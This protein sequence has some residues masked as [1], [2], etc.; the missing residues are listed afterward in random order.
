MGIHT[1]GQ[2]VDIRLGPL[3]P[4]GGEKVAQ[5]R[6]HRRRLFPIPKNQEDRMAIEP[7]RRHP[8]VVDNADRLDLAHEIGLPFQDAAY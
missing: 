4:T 7:V 2:R 1:N 8:D 3:P 6:L 5:R